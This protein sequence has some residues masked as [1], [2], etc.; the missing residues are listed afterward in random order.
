MW[1]SSFTDVLPTLSNGQAVE[2]ADHQSVVQLIRHSGT[3]VR[4]I[5]VSVTDEE[6]RK[7]EPESSGVSAMDYFE[8][9][10]VPLSVPDTKKMKD[11][12][13][14]KDYV[15]YNIYMANKYLTSRRYREFDALNTNV[16]GCLVFK[17]LLT[18]TP[19][20]MHTHP[21]PHTYTPTH[22]HT[23]IHTHTHTCS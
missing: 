22:T 7:L 8:R 13:T 2:G 9:R 12:A 11:E 6:A 1:L 10:S 18:C 4:L 23:H 17:H 14:G 20:H 15:V 21:H 3:E 19:T 16:S 5:V